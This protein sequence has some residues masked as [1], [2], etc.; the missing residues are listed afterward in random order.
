MGQR[1]GPA[2]SLAVGAAFI[3]FAVLKALSPGPV[4]G[5]MSYLVG[6]PAAA[7]RLPVTALVLG[8]AV[9]GAA[10]PL[11]FAPRATL[12]IAT[13]TLVLFTGALLYLWFDPNA[14]SCGCAGAARLAATARQENA[15]AISR[16]A[17][18]LLACAL[19]LRF[20]RPSAVNYAEEGAA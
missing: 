7:L 5:S 16:N 12:R 2:A 18:L 20:D 14:P 15:M 10:M 1:L 8:E 13:A 6:A 4:L 17:L 11:R 3:V 19:G 9:L